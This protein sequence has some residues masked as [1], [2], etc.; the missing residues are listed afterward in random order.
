VIFASP[1]RKRKGNVRDKTVLKARRK[2]SGNGNSAG[3]EVA[4]T[5]V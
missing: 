2:T 1:Q 5:G 4:K 3:N